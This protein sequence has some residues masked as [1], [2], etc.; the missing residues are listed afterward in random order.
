MNVT[1]CLKC[2]NLYEAWSEEEANSPSRRC[3]KCMGPP[4]TG[5]GCSPEPSGVGGERVTNGGPATATYQRERTA[6]SV[7][8][9]IAGPMALVYELERMIFRKYPEA[10]YGTRIADRI[11][12]DQNEVVT[13]HRAASCD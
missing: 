6:S 8:Y 3:R 12:A 2:G 7:I 1:T 11:V 5:R 4:N 9:T 10:G 13:I